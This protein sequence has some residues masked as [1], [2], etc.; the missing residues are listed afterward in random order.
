MALTIIDGDCKP[1]RERASVVTIPEPRRWCWTAGKVGLAR[2]PIT[3][4]KYVRI[5]LKMF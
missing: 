5:F 3:L 4:G 1:A 2:H